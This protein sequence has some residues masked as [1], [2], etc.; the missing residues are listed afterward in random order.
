[1]RSSKEIMDLI[2]SVAA[3]DERVRVVAMNGSRTNPN[4][5]KD[6]FQDYDIVFL[7]TDMASFLR[8]KSWV[9]V[10]GPRMIMQTP[11]DGR[12]FPPSL[13]GWYTYLMLFDDDNRIDLMLIPMTDLDKY[14]K[15]DRLTTILLDKE[16]C[17]P[18]LPEPSDETF[19]VKRPTLDQFQGSCN[20]FWWLVPYVVKGICRKELIYAQDHLTLLRSEV[21]RQLAWQVGYDTGF[22]VSVGK[23]FK[24]VS[25]YVSKETLDDVAKTYASGTLDACAQVL[26]HI[27]PLFAKVAEAVAQE[28]DFVYDKREEEKITAYMNRYLKELK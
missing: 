8:D 15:N 5:P 10:F 20:E 26:K 23:S 16:G 25:A 11:E 1:M 9:D 19:W 14:L 22:S 17:V 4:V 28:G 18:T 7:V 27:C 3:Q 21:L 13:G 6:A 12:L 2:L 24:Y